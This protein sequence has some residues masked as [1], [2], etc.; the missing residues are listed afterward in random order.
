MK[1][2]L[3]KKEFYIDLIL[4]ITTIL[5]IYS[6]FNLGILGLKYVLPVILV[7]FIVDLFLIIKANKKYTFKSKKKLSK[8]KL[9]DAKVEFEKKVKKKRRIY[10]FFT[11]IVSIIYLAG[12]F[13][14]LNIHNSM[15]NLFKNEST[16]NYSVLV[17]KN[18]D[19]KEIDDLNEKIIGFYEEDKYNELAEKKLSKK[20]DCE[21]I[22]YSSIDELKYALRNE[23]I[24]GM[25]IMDSYLD[26]DKNTEEEVEA[27][28]VTSNEEV[29]EE[30]SDILEKIEDFDTKT[31]T[32][33]KF[34]I[35]I[36]NSKNTKSI[37]LE[38]GSF[39]IYVSGEDSY[40]DEVNETSRSDVNMLVVVNLKTRNVLLLSIP[41]DYYI[42]INSKGAY[43][44]LTHI[45]LYGSEEAGNSLGA[46][47]DVDVDYF[48]KFNF[49]TFMKAT[50]YLL[51]LDVYSD[52]DFTTSVY[53]RTIGDCYTF[54]KGYNHITNGKMALQFVRARKNFAQ[55]DRQ[56]GINQTRFLRAVINKATTPSVL[57][58]YNKILESLEGT[59]LTNVDN[60]S[61]INIIK[62]VLNHNGKFNI[63]SMALD[64]YDAHR[65][66]YSGGST[67]LY[68]MIPNQKTI[69][70]AKIAIKA[71]LDGEDPDIEKDASELA[72]T[73]DTHDVK[74]APTNYG[75]TNVPR[76]IKP[77]PEK[78]EVKEE[79][80]KE[81]EPTD[82]DKCIGD[83]C[84]LDDN[85]S[86]TGDG[87]GTGDGGSGTGDGDGTDTGT[88]D[89]GSDGGGTPAPPP[90]PSTPTQPGTG[91]TV[92]ND[93]SEILYPEE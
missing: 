44:K 10:L 50:E 5:L 53:D 28:D 81:E 32:I 84:P 18:S 21:Y 71:V 6:I 35:N 38:K 41:R 65:G 54:S 23:D 67:P 76:V 20:I 90:E 7:I 74:K 75:T 77:V 72:S 9:L 25:M 19:Y 42:K 59:F 80:K 58:K 16:I 63:Y 39:V 55:G 46:L 92:G 12:F 64:G 89:G 30:D 62:Y 91:S 37:D 88:D 57:L 68:V 83:D 17:N 47:L 31:K 82:D 22:G 4:I 85:P 1:N 61:I 70:S 87:D 26:L 66:T 36:D 78:E 60:E 24:D 14:L 33:Y 93:D 34:K 15:N 3:K 13:I 69:D 52:Y 45:S 73:K 79:E 2:V 11:V 86:G 48:V 27:E 40:S 51:P 8:K 56:R 29:V 49:T 43:D